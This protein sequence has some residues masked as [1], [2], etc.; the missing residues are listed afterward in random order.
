MCDCS[1]GREKW[2]LDTKCLTDCRSRHRCRNNRT[3][4]AA[5]VLHRPVK[6]ITVSDL[7]SD[8]AFFIKKKKP[9]TDC[10]FKS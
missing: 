10:F 2:N 3:T 5:P 8:T 7:R 6:D 9:P 1:F 4:P